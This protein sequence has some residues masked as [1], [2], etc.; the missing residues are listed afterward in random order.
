MATARRSVQ[1]FI[2]QVAA[3]TTTGITYVATLLASGAV[4]I[5]RNG[6]TIFPSVLW[7][8]GTSEALTD[9][10]ISGDSVTLMNNDG[11][12]G[13]GDAQLFINSLV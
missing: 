7:A 13:R 2:A 12:T 3:R 6:T 9:L 10:N 5:S 8:M 1:D 4:Q 11:T